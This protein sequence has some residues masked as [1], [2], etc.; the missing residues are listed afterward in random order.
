MRPPVQILKFLAIDVQ[1]FTL[2]FYNNIIKTGS[3]FKETTVC[4]ATDRA[5]TAPA[6]A[7]PRHFSPERVL[8][9]HWETG[10]FPRRLNQDCS[11]G[12]QTVAESILVVGRCVADAPNTSI[13]D[14]IY[15]IYVHIS[16]ATS[17][18]VAPCCCAVALKVRAN[19]YVILP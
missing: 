13:Q 12:G 7:E 8:S 19:A 14:N 2:K 10:A 6:G 3:E 9:R 5:Y 16:D 4:T 18:S 15:T 1:L 17:R 11:A